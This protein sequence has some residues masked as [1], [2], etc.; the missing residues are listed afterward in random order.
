L[1]WLLKH[2]WEDIRLF[3]IDPVGQKGQ[4][5]VQYEVS[6][7]SQIVRWHQLRRARSLGKALFPRYATKPRVPF[8]DYERQ[9][10]V[11]PGLIVAKTGLLLADLHR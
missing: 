11:L 3:A 4:P 7:A 10:D 6:T 2:I 8:D 5:P 1:C 9:M